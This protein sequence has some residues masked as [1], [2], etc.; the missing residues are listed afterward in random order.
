MARAERSGA[1]IV[2]LPHR[3]V[4]YGEARPDIIVSAHTQITNLS[5]VYPHGALTGH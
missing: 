3:L 1:L 5:D 4:R 2:L